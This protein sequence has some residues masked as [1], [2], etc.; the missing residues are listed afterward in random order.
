MGI[1]KMTRE[2]IGIVSTL[3][4]PMIII[5]TKTDICPKNILNETKN[6]IKKIVKK[7]NKMP[8][9]IYDEKDIDKIEDNYKNSDYICPIFY[10]SNVTGEN[11]PLFKNFLYK[12]NSRY[13]WNQY[14]K[15]TM[16]NTK[17]VFIIDDLFHIK[18]I[19]NI[20]FGTVQNGK[21]KHHQE[22]Y[23]GPFN[24]KYEK[25]N[26]KTLNDN[27]HNFVDELNI[28]DTGCLLFKSNKKNELDRN[29]IKKGMIV[30]NK[31]NTIGFKNFKANILIL[32]HPTQIKE[33]YQ[34]V[35]HCGNVSQTAKITDIDNKVLRTGD[36]A[37]VTFS[38]LHRPEY[39]KD[40][41]LFFREGKTKG[42]GK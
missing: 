8:W 23:I 9:D 24:G 13:N 27:N 6:K 19:G 28:G 16:D 7:I 41:P 10:I 34:P 39:E 26:I 2:H 12:L 31:E 25:I 38:F 1:T 30:T 17:N 42:V 14:K 20:L 37:N 32:H 33:N 40:T 3:Q 36:R 35:I 15:I 21:I 11:I 4:K 5:I 18:G 29:S 22:M